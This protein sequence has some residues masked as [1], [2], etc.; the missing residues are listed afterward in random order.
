MK[1]KVKKGTFGNVTAKI[2]SERSRWVEVE[3]ADKI[4]FNGTPCTLDAVLKS[5]LLFETAGNPETARPQLVTYRVNKEN[6]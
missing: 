5:T 4:N 2:F 6:K 1:A 3:M